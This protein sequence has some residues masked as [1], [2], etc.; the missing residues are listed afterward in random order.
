MTPAHRFEL[1]TVV[2]QMRNDGL[3]YDAA[4]KEFE[5]QYLRE[6]LMAHRGNQ[7]KAAEELGHH[8]NTISRKME[9]LGLPMAE[10]KADVKRQPKS[11]RF[12]RHTSDLA[13]I[14]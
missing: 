14:A 2:A 10:I 8:R 7:C 6:V 13:E 9:A 5:K 4:V 11:I 1:A 12:S 3:S